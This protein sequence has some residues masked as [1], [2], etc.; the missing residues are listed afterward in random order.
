[1]Q[2]AM[3]HTP[4]SSARPAPARRRA[5]Q[6]TAAGAVA[7]AFPVLLRARTA[8]MTPMTEGPFYP[9]PAWR[10]R[11]TDWDAD[12]TTVRRDGRTLVAQGEA[13]DLQAQVLDTRGRVLDAAEVE[14]WQC[15]AQAVY[16]HPSVSQAGDPGFAGFGAARADA[17][18]RVRFRTIRPVP[19]PGRTPH[20][21][22]RVRHASFGEIVT[23]LFVAG[24][25]G[26]ARD[27]LWRRLDTDAQRG[28]A[29][30][31]AP[32]AAGSGLAWTT[33]QMLV[34]PG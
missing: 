4:P 30:A 9:P 27:F 12:L 21:H 18:G 16:R 8:A 6:R 31:L 11:W 28:L 32:A 25:T 1:M 24:D 26:N 23:Q 14:I 5:L 3:P 7:L 20:I 17:E 22:L 13:L 29:M 33:R 10:D 15:D 19:Y 34:V 2:C